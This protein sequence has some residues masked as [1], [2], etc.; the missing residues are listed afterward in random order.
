MEIIYSS[1]EML[2][3]FKREKIEFEIR[4]KTSIGHPL[5][6]IHKVGVGKPVIITAGA[7]ASEPSGVSAACE[8][9]KNW[10]Y[11]FPLYM[12]PLRDPFG[13]MGYA[14]CLETVIGEEVS[15]SSYEDVTRILREKANAMYC[16]RPDFMLAE[17][18]SVLFANC[19][20]NPVE[21]GPRQ[22]EI[23]TNEFLKANPEKIP[24]F[25][26]KRIVCP[27]NFNEESE[28]VGCYERAFTAEITAY[29]VFADY[30]RRFGTDEEPMEVRV[31]RETIDLIEPRL[32]LDLH[33]GFG[34]T[35]YYF[36]PDYNVNEK[37]RLYIQ[38]M[39]N[40]VRDDFSEPW[41]LTGIAACIPS[42]A[43][44]FVEPIPGVIADKHIQRNIGGTD[45][46]KFGGPKGVSFG[47]YAARYCPA[48]TIESGSVNTLANRVKVHLKSVYSVLDAIAKEDS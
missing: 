12:F 32:A 46:T 35:Y 40:S 5:I 2:D 43:E 6:M 14:K 27:A 19:R 1:Q 26:G 17:I 13:C 48:V 37:T 7:H 11:P 10:R 28:T 18:N 9:I 36:A 41:R 31:V 29:G 45:M 4:G 39:I 21:A 30:N 3:F 15:I 42:A 8:I 22:S 34:S 16:D 25:A 33:E 47:G 23:N 24:E 38:Q 44:E 20:Y